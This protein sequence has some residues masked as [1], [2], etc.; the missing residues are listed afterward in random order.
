MARH[1]WAADRLWEGLIGGDEDRWTRGLAVLADSP[2]PFGPLTDAPALATQLQR[3]A[4]EQLD[5][6]AMTLPDGRATAY[7]E[8]LVTCAACHSSLHVVTP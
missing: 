8:M 6:R 7:G 2:L 4:R 1:V 5:A 3:R